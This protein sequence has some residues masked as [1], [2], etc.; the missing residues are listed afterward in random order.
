V[1][2][3]ISEQRISTIATTW[4][5]KT[6]TLSRNTFS[7]RSSCSL[8][9][10]RI[11]TCIYCVS[12]PLT[13]RA[14]LKRS[15][16]TRE[17]SQDAIIARAHQD[18]LNNASKPSL[19]IVRTRTGLIL[20]LIRFQLNL[21]RDVFALYSAAPPRGGAQTHTWRKKTPDCVTAIRLTSPRTTR[22]TIC[23][24][25]TR[26]PVN[27]RWTGCR[28]PWPPSD[29]RRT[30]RAIRRWPRSSERRLFRWRASKK[31]KLIAMRPIHLTTVGG[32]PK[33]EQ[34]FLSGRWRWTHLPKE[35]YGESLSCRGSNTQPSTW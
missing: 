33:P 21:L 28:R 6:G 2:L 20:N 11:W 7:A 27:R 25:P 34:C 1:R 4:V 13:T 30:G 35:R 15:G 18:L 10:R 23:G 31:I 32:R 17:I 14:R 8:R 26:P 29:W 16:Y 3:S 24:S 5:P 12:N 22:C 9:S 19:C